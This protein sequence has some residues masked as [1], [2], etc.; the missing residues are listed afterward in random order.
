MVVSWG[1]PEGKAVKVPGDMVAIATGDVVPIAT[2]D[3]VAIA[4]SGVVMLNGFGVVS[5]RWSCRYLPVCF[6]SLYLRWIT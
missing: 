2:G 1:I 3:V 5:R 4:T 6:G